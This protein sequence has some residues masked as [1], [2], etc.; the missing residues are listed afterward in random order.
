MRVVIAILLVANLAVAAWIFSD[1]QRPTDDAPLLQSQINADRIRV[2]RGAEE[3]V[4]PVPL[5]DAC[6]EWSPFPSDE[7]ARARTA[8]A[9]A[10]YGERLYAAPVSVTAGWWVYIPPQPSADAAA[11]KVAELRQFGIAETFVVQERGEWENAISLGIFRNEDGAR[12]FLELLRS[13]GV[14]T[15]VSGARQQQVRQNGLYLR[16]PVAND[17]LALSALQARFPG[18]TVRTVR[19]P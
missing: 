5:A 2:V 1:A 16:Q 12:R 4:A 17:A 13:K 18:T 7:L 19:C 8:L 9:D 15:A 6:I 11:R 14:R 10:A 3:P